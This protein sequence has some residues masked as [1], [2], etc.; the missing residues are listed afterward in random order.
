MNNPKYIVDSSILILRDSEE[1]YEETVYP[2][3]W[4]N[5]DKLIEK[6]DIIS[7]MEVKKELTRD[8]HDE[9]D[10]WVN[11]HEYMFKNMDK[12]SSEMLTKLL[13]NFQNGIS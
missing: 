5:L 2:I 13:L 4:Y 3:H 11:Q 1:T 6:G 12:A 10:E 8:G 9:H 7:I